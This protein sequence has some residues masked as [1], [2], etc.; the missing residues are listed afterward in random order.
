[1][2]R[3]GKIS[4]NNVLVFF[5]YLYIILLPIGTG[6]AGIIG[7]ISLMNYIAI[8]IVIIGIAVAAYNGT[9][10]ISGNAIPT[11]LYFVYTITSYLWTSNPGFTWYVATNMVNGML[12]IILNCYD[13]TESE[14]KKIDTC[15]IISQII[16]YMAVLRNINSM[17]VYRLNITIVSTIGIG[18]FAVGLCLLIAFW[19]NKAAEA[20]KPYIKILSYL[21]VISNLIIILMAGSRGALA[22][23][24]VM[25]A[26]WILL[27]DYKQRTKAVIIIVI[28]TAYLFITQEFLGFLPDIIKNRMTLEA[29]RATNG[30]GRFNIWRLAF[31]RFTSSN[32]FNIFFGHGFNSFL[33][34]ISYGSH[35]GFHDLMAHNA[36][37]QTM[38]EGGLIGIILMFRMGFHQVRNAWKR[39]DTMML[40]AV[41]GLF[42]AGLSNDMQV[43]RIWGMILTL[44]CLKDGM[45]QRQIKSYSINGNDNI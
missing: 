41:V 42:T 13:W 45:F 19:M 31:E 12:F 15:I 36:V 39:K 1:M 3:K 30:S 35:G 24:F 40:L 22:M 44:N 27:G 17:F 37:V 10:I 5:V 28:I 16:V 18:D 21:A 32:V 43:T 25:A 14:V 11:F 9:M 4:L 7:S 38:I 8:A 33:H 6:L 34:E 26:V 29:I 23:F 2:A 20:S